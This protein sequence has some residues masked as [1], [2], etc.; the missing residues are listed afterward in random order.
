MGRRHVDDGKII[1]GI[2]PFLILW[3]LLKKRSS[4]WFFCCD[5]RKGIFLNRTQD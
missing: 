1:L 5:P 3:D 4:L 2:T